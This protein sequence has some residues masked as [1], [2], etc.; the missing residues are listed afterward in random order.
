[1]EDGSDD[2]GGGG[3]GEGGDR[4]RREREEARWRA[5]TTTAAAASS[6]FSQ[7]SSS[8]FPY[9]HHQHQGSSSSSSSSSSS[10]HRF[11]GMSAAKPPS[12]DLKKI[13][14]SVTSDTD[15]WTCVL[16]FTRRL[17]CIPASTCKAHRALIPYARSETRGA[18]CNR[19]TPT[20]STLHPP[21]PPPPALTFPLPLSLPPT[22]HTHSSP[23]A[24]SSPR[25]QQA[26]ANEPEQ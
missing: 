19:L 21:H 4:R 6:S 12:D 16:R 3:G 9:H 2:C 10:H 5:A 18:C 24:L 11:G 14:D 15:L 1:M 25:E 26:R 8:T 13:F 22:L 23:R 17:P 20:P 7:A